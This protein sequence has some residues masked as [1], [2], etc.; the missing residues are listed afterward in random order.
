MHVHVPTC[1]QVKYIIMFMS[2]YMLR[3]L[4]VSAYMLRMLL[5]SMFV[6]PNMLLLMIMCA[7][8]AYAFTNA[9]VWNF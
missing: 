7:V 8:S 5:M 9:N 3:M 4:L 2:A 6:L 1:R